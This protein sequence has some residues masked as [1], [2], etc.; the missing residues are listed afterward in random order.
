V[1]SSDLDIAVAYK[2][3]TDEVITVLREAFEGLRT[4]EQIARGIIGG[5]EVDGIERFEASAVVIRIRIKTRPG[6]QAPVGRA[7]NRLIKL[8]FDEHGIEMPFPQQTIWLGQSADGTPPLL[9]V[10]SE[11]D[12]P[13]A[14][15]ARKPRSA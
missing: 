12:A 14:V 7:Y 3:N 1:C 11:A 4:D 15:P 9:Q 6:Q 5:L 2:E 10:R 13:P 8:A